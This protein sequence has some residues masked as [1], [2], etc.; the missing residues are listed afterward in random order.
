[1]EEYIDS[2]FGDSE[3]RQEQPTRTETVR[4]ALI[5]APLCSGTS[6]GMTKTR[7]ITDQGEAPLGASLWP[8]TGAE[9]AIAPLKLQQAS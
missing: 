7:T 5:G 3:Q 9:L 1:M 4:C 6:E 2:L 8:A